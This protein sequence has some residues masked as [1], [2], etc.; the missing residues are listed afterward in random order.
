M[1]KSNLAKTV[2]VIA[3]LYSERSSICT[4]FF[5]Q[6]HRFSVQLR[7]PY[8]GTYQ[9]YETKYSRVSRPYPLKYFKG[10]LPQNL[11]SPPLNTLSH[12]TEL[13]FKSN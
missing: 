7:K 5:D 4:H 2:R 10:C 11:L 1:D 12:M 13:F 3:S 8:L 9:T 6:N